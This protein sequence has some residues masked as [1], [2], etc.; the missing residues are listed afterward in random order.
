[1]NCN[2]TCNLSEPSA[3]RR[4]RMDGRWATVAA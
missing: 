1:M 4:N 3:V 2:M